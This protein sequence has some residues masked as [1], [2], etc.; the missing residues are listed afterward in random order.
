MSKPTVSKS[1]T[2]PCEDLK[3]Q[4]AFA[5]AKGLSGWRAMYMFAV[6]QYMNRSPLTDRELSIYNKKMAEN[7]SE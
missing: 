3:E 7:K 6:N 4:E 1:I 2:I 5:I